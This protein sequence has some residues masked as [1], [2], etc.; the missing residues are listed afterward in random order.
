M[1]NFPSKIPRYNQQSAGS[2]K[3]PQYRAYDNVLRDQD[4]RTTQRAVIDEY[5]AMVN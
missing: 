5:G 4:Y 2:G 1:G 3:K